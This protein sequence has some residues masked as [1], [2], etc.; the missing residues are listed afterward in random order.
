VLRQFGRWHQLAKMRAKAK[1]R[2]IA[3]HGPDLRVN[4]FNRAVHFC[5][6]LDQHHHALDQMS[7]TALDRYYCKLTLG[8]Q[9]AL[10]PFLNWATAGGHMPRLSY[11]QPRF[12]VG[13]AMSQDQRL[14]LL[15]QLI[16]DQNAPLVPRV[17]ACIVLL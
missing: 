8:H 14:T 16:L 9:H 12:N 13:E 17:A 11:S 10:R 4:G 6:W 5:T 15:R 3:A 2:P 1:T 7:Q